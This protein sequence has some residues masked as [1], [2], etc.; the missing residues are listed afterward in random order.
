MYGR[1]VCQHGALDARIGAMSTCPRGTGPEESSPFSFDRVLTI[2]FCLPGTVG[3]RH[4]GR[5]GEGAG[6]QP[7]RLS[8]LVCL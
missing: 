8:G 5:I 3:S 1:L 6:P 2:P 4:W 7:Y